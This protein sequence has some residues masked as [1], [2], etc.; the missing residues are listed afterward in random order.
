MEKCPR[1]GERTV[2]QKNYKFIKEKDR[3]DIS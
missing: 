2:Q 3:K 1:K